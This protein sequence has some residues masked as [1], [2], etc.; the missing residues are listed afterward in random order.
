MAEFVK[1]NF[2]G[3]PKFHTQI[4]MFILDTIVSQMDLE[5][6]CA[7]CFNVRALPVTVQNIASL[8][9][10]FDHHLCALK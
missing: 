3:H 8:V 7:A 6:V 2:T 10:T 1:D 9:D 4:V 5:G